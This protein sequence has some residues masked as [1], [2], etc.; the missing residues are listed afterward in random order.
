MVSRYHRKQSPTLKH[1]EFARLSE[2][3]RGVVRRMAGVLRV[4][5]GLDRGHA[6]VVDQLTTRLTKDQ[7]SIRVAPKK[8][9]A[10]LSLEIWGASRKADLLAK[11]LDRSVAI[12][13]GA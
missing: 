9:G 7:L 4:A 13:T 11:L 8:L 2:E 6:A 5:D 12:T 3:D 1:K 10:D